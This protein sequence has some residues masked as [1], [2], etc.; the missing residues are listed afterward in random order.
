MSDKGAKRHTVYVRDPTGEQQK[1][2]QVAE[3]KAIA[4]VYNGIS[5]A[6]M[7]ATPLDLS[8][9]ALGF[10]LTEKIIATPQQLKNIEIIRSD[11]GYEIQMD[12]I[13]SAWMQLKQRRR[14]LNGRTGCGICGLESLEAVQPVVQIVR[15]AVLPTYAVVDEAMQ[16]MQAQQ[17]LHE[18]CGA[19]HAAAFVD[20]SGHVVALREDIGRHNA[21]DKLLGAIARRNTNEGFITVSSRASYEMIYKTATQGISTLIAASAPT[22]MAIELAHQAQMN[23]IGFVKPGRQSIYCQSAAFIENNEDKV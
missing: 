11:L 6:V 17:T 4:M 22:M 19:V 18:Q 13:G 12:I 1:E 10:S 14:Q 20:A 2:D 23:L 3:E 15:A 21:L 7:M 16:E 9:F 5:H 8:D